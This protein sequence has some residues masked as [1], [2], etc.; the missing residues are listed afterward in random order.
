VC[1]SLLA[2]T[3][4]LGR[5]PSAQRV[6]VCAVVRR[7]THFSCE[8]PELAIALLE[9]AKGALVLLV[10]LGFFSLLHHDV[11]LAA[12]RLV[13]HA[14]LDPAARYPRIFLHLAGEITDGRVL[15]LAA[16]ALLYSGARFVEAYGLWLGRRW[17]EW[18]AALGGA[19]YIPFD[20]VE[21]HQRVTLLSVGVLALNVA[22]VAF[23]V[24]SGLLE[25][26]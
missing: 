12:E 5:Q 6:D 8:L 13:A 20:L 19:I 22:I 15:L 1:A 18:F 23:M 21:L 3:T 17:A 25:S 10:G 26:I 14:H 7:H 4:S 16:G 2:T 9:G 11:Q 24:A